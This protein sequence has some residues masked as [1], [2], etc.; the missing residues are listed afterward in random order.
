[1]EK[2]KSNYENLL[3]N[4]IAMQHSS[5]YATRKETLILAEIAITSLENRLNVANEK[6]EL[7]ERKAQF[8][9]SLFERMMRD[10]WRSPSDTN[11]MYMMADA[12]YE[13]PE[14]EGD[15]DE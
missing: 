6:L 15:E 2:V 14:E 5:Y 9:D 8:A 10:G 13:I 7:A 4:L 1:M 3:N 11:I 12:G